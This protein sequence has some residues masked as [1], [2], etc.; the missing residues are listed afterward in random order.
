MQNV[1]KPKIFIGSTIEGLE[2]AEAIQS[3]LEH[4]A[5][6]TV[7]TQ[8]VFN[9]SGN[10]LDDLISTLEYFDYGIFVFQPNDKSNIRNTEFNTVRDNVIFELGLYIGKLGRDRAF[11][12]V[13]RNYPNLHLPTDLAGITAGT[14]D[15]ERSQS[16]ENLEALV[17]PF[18]SKIKKVLK[19]H[20]PKDKY[21]GIIKAELFNNFTEEF[22]K[23]I[24]KSN[25]IGLFF[26]HSR[27][28][29]ENNENSIISFL[30]KKKCKLIIFLPNILNKDLMKLI[31]NNFADGYVIESLVRDAYRYFLQLQEIYKSKVELRSFN[32]YPTYSF[33]SFDKEAIIALYPTT[34]KKKN[35]PAFRIIKDSKFWKFFEDD[36]EEL[37]KQT[38]LIPRKIIIE[39]KK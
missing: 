34:A 30:S 16:D 28:W 26:I 11:Y 8:G 15:Y 29:R 7:W 35:V 23:L 32:Y 36:F 27:Q 21:I 33:Y 22:E 14:Y 25:K 39:L 1:K 5:Y 18:C 3:N 38:K 37:K 12:L 10:T 20:K 31:V 13:P 17:G 19:K 2:I 6:P 9:I 24:L 4:I